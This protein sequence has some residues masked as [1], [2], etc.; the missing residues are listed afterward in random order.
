MIFG[1]WLPSCPRVS[2]VDVL[3]ELA[4]LR[5]IVVEQAGL[6]AELQRQR[7]RIP[8]RCRVRRRRMRRGIRSRQRNARHG[9]GPGGNRENRRVRRR[10]PRKLT[11][12]PNAICQVAPDRCSGCEESLQDPGRPPGYVVRWWMLPRL[13]HRR[14]PSINWCRAVA[15]GVDMSANPPPPTFPTRSLS[16]VTSGHR[17][18]MPRTRTTR[19][20][21][22][23]RG[24]RT[25]RCRAQ[26]RVGYCHCR[27]CGFGCGAGVTS[28]KP[29]AYRAAS[30]GA[31]RIADLRALPA[32]RPRHHPAGAEHRHS[33]LDRV[34]RWGPQSRC[35]RAG[36][37]VSP[38]RAG[39]TGVTHSRTLAR[40]GGDGNSHKQCGYVN[41][42][43]V[44]R[45]RYQRRL[46]P[47]R[48]G[49]QGGLPQ[50]PTFLRL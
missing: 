43:V 5:R 37:R 19:K 25:S 31:A 11:D 18:A 1:C 12:D 47:E 46:L 7:G 44:R 23:Y 41:L 36:S 35:C 4:V 32:D 45:R 10:R 29:G 24:C 50:P 38:P 13:S 34:H 48:S 49:V 15:A 26:C 28:G 40:S 20:I 39:T 42:P 2:L 14:S 27:W 17:L 9:P 22:C 6:I 16:I 3:A 30:R 21:F 33:G 8:R